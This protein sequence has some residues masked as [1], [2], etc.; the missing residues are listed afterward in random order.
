MEKIVN[1]NTI[2]GLLVIISILLFF[3]LLKKEQSISYETNT[4]DVSVKQKATTTSKKE[5]DNTRDFEIVD[6]RWYADPNYGSKGTV[7]WIV[8]IKNKTDQYVGKVRVEFTTYDSDKR[9]ITTSHAYI[10]TFTPK[11][12]AS[13][14][15]YADYFGTE[16]SAKIRVL[17][18]I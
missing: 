9:L 8:E 18:N 14:K 15:M 2:F 13:T 12:T 7:I 3:N 10:G 4:Y 1:K 16:T 11:G 17:P 6:W 5:I